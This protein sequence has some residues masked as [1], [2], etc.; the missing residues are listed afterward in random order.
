MRDLGVSSWG[1]FISTHPVS[2]VPGILA[3]PNLPRATEEFKG[4]RIQGDFN[5]WRKTSE[6]RKQHPKARAR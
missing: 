4:Y 1:Y 2:V 6:K 3:M 5:K